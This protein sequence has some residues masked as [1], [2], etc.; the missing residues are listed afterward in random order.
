MEWTPEKVDFY[1]NN[2]VFY[3]VTK[4]QAGS[5]QQA[6]PFDQPFWIQLNVA[7]GGPYGQS[8]NGGNWTIPHTMEVDWVKVYQK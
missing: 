3:T 5:T 8:P 2:N 7:V 4:A 6:W 1:L